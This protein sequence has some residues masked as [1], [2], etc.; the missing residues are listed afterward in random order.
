M[1]NKRIAKLCKMYNT[2]NNLIFECP[3]GQN[4]KYNLEKDKENVTKVKIYICGTQNSPGKAA[5]GEVTFEQVTT[6]KAQKLAHEKGKD[7][8]AGSLL[9]QHCTQQGLSEGLSEGW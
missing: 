1:E 6:N 2:Q 7:L 5:A 9:H 8:K 3:K 4:T